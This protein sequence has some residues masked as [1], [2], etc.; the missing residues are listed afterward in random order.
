MKQFPND[1]WLE[2]V[3]QTWYW[4]PT[5]QTLHEAS[6]PAVNAHSPTVIKPHTERKKS[7]HGLSV[8]TGPCYLVS[9]QAPG[10]WGG[11]SSPLDTVVMVTPAGGTGSSWHWEEGSESAPYLP[12]VALDHGD[13]VQE[14]M[15]MERIEIYSGRAKNS[16][17]HEGGKTTAGSPKLCIP[18]T[19]PCFIRSV[20]HSG[21]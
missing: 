3:I 2:T 9:S 21:V 11:S 13:D 17:S 7:F 8:V 18:W 4:H 10:L 6:S 14:I 1:P 15:G 16:N 5:L 20:R 12:D 19:P